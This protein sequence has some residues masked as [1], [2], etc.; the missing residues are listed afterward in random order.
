MR[1]LVA[2]LGLLDGAD[3][4]IGEIVDR[5]A[6]L[7]RWNAFLARI[8]KTLIGERFGPRFEIAVG[9]LR[10]DVAGHPF[11][12]KGERAFGHLQLLFCG[13]SVRGFF[14]R[15]ILLPPPTRAA[16]ARTRVQAWWGRPANEVSREAGNFL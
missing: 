14:V 13:E 11:I 6:D 15:G 10:P 8:G 3:H 1:V 16:L 5:L 12:D 7:G 4:E 9:V 2:L